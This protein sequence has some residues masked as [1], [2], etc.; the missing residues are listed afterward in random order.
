MSESGFKDWLKRQPSLDTFIVTGRS[1]LRDRNGE[2]VAEWTKTSL[3]RDAEER[4]RQAAFQALCER[5][6]RVERLKAPDATEKRLATV[7][8]LTDCHVGML[9]W[10]REGGDDWDI[11]I[12]ERTLL[13]CFQAMIDAAPNA[14]LAIVNQLGDFMHYDGLLAVTPTSGHHLDADGRFEKM[15]EAAIRIL[16]QIVNMALAKHGRVHMVLAE[17]NH[18]IASSIWLR[19]MFKALYEDEPRLSVDD[20]A[21][22][23]YALQHGEVMLAFHHGHLKKNDQ[24]PLLFASQFSKMWGMT[25]KRYAHTGHRHHVE[26]KEWSGMTVCQH[27]TLAARDA[28]AAR[29]GWI[30]ER[31][32]QAITYHAEHGEVGRVRVSPEMVQ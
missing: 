26:E 18:D 9:A 12:A 23:F 27:P 22:P 4:A 2:V 13:G 6:P 29:G 32:A 30:A 5:L 3:D 16:R 31:A 15:V 7:Y 17:G 24:L 19:K 8:T 28:Y 11:S 10:H 14:E 20:S 25:T 1:T 21:L